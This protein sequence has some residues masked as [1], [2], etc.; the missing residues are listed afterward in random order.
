MKILKVVDILVLLK[1]FLFHP[2]LGAFFGDYVF[3]FWGFL[4][5]SNIFDSYCCQYDVGR[6]RK[7]IIMRFVN[8]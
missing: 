2:F 4:S 5:K 8:F 3:I 6:F 7:S 1:V